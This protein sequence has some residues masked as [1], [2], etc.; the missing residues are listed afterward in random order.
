M[1]KLIWGICYLV[2]ALPSI[3]WRAI[4]RFM[5]NWREACYH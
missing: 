1:L 3:V 2:L 4:P 5:R